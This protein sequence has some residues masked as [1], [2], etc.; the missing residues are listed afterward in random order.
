MSSRCI[1]CG[2]TL[3]FDIELQKVRCE[4]CDSIFEPEEYRVETA[5]GENKDDTYETT[6]FTCPNCGGQISSTEFDAIDYC[7]YCGSF[8]SLERQMRNVKMPDKILPFSQ[9]KDDCKR[10]YKKALARKIYAPKEFRDESFIDGF[11]GVYVPFWNFKYNYGPKVR[12]KGEMEERDGDYINTHHYVTECDVTGEVNLNTYDAS[13]NFDDE[14]SL[15]IAPFHTEN[16]K[17]FNTAYMF[18]FYGDTA[19]IDEGLYADESTEDVENEI[20][21]DLTHQKTAGKGHFKS[22]KPK[23]FA[24]DINLKK[25]SSLV[26]LPIWFL[27]WR[28]NDRIAYSVVNGQTGDVYTETPVDIIRYIIFSLITAIPIFF[29][30]NAVVTYSA[31]NMLVNSII[32]S[33]IMGMAYIFE[34]DKIV[35]RIMHTDD[36]GFLE[37]HEDAKKSSED[38]VSDN[39]FSIFWEFLKEGFG[40]LGL[41]SILLIVGSIFLLSE[42]ILIALIVLVI[43]V[44]TYSIYR[45]RK[46]AKILKDKTIWIDISGIF[47]SIFYG[48]I[49]LIADPAPDK[50]FY[51]ASMLGMAG[52]GF[53]AIRMVKRY[54][55]LITRPLPHFFDEKKG[56]NA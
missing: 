42:F 47:F 25:S 13:S 10:A 27:T 45:L 34:L 2:G 19:D 35:R 38:Q 20:W 6:E 30:L 44:P 9:T 4:N 55:E 53:A 49:L 5:A 7:M 15:R 23:S 24:S 29:I 1:N 54:N 33:A 51:Y 40:E 32:L 52:V 28:K 46:N 37:K 56:G 48:T 16:L 22:E 11:R 3:I 43:C 39:V 26:M 21:H 18:G 17:D 12:L 8:V 14:I 41:L 50:F 31:K 36:R